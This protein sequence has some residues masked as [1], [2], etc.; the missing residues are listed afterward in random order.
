MA[1]RKIE[2]IKVKTL[3]K[4]RDKYSGKVHKVGDVFSVTKERFDEI[5]KAGKF[6][7]LHNEAEEKTAK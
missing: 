2:K 3:L 1:A 5:L 4:F 6:V 7:E